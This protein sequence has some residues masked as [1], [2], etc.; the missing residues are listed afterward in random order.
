MPLPGSRILPSPP[1][2]DAQLV[3]A[4]RSVVTPHISDNL[5]RHIGAR[6]LTR[7]N[8]TG[9]LVGT[10]LTV[11]TRPGDN[12]Y[13]YKALTLLQ[14]GHVLVID[15]QGDTSNAA[16]GELIKLYALQ[17]GCAGFVIDGAIR[18]VAAFADTPCYARGVVHCG[19]YKTGPGEINVPVS[20]GGMIVNPGDLVVGDE[21]GLVAFAQHDAPAVLA[22]AAQHAAHEAQVMAEIATGNPRQSWIEAPLKKFGLLENCL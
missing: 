4:L 19:P 21:D 9:K 20:V 22:A 3:E 13:I 12:L 11:K 16:I 18:D 14:P 1:L 2:A 8:R 17:R 5:G 7:F 10:A 15:A 6:G